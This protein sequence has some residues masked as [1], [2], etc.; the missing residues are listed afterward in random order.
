M[1]HT[2]VLPSGE[3]NMAAFIILIAILALLWFWLQRRKSNRSSYGDSILSDDGYGNHYNGPTIAAHD[4][5]II[6][7]GGGD[8]GGAGASGSWDS[9]GGDSGGGD[10]GGGGD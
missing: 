3:N 7:G 10:G 4:S 8:F 5:P 9:G 6:A 2:V 1:R